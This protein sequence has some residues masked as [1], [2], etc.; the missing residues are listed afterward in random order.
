MSL[1]H[2]VPRGAQERIQEDKKTNKKESY[3]VST[4]DSTLKPITDCVLWNQNQNVRRADAV[5]HV[6]NAGFAIQ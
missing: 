4:K 6:R 2:P 5:M 3:Q 1:R